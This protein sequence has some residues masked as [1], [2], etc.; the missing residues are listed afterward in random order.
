MTILSSPQRRKNPFEVGLALTT[1]QP[2][3]QSVPNQLVKTSSD[4]MQC[5]AIQYN[6]I[7]KDYQIVFIYTEKNTYQHIL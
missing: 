1:T 2:T 3:R 5:N 4:T 6:T 7:R